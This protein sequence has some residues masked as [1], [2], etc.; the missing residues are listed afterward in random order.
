MSTGDVSARVKSNTIHDI[1][2]MHFGFE[3]ETLRVHQQMTFAPCDF[4]ACVIATRATQTDGF[5]TLAV[6][7][8]C[9][10]LSF[11]SHLFTHLHAQCCMK[12]FPEAI[13]IPQ[14]KVVIHGFLRRQI[15]G[16]QTPSASASQQIE[17]GIDDL[18]VAME[19]R[20]SV[21]R[22]SREKRSNAVPFRIAQID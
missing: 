17:N 16:K 20:P 10:G 9:T 3:D 21:K 14:T 22:G 6:N 11:T 12:S 13:F 18:T 7:D 2:C 15:V 8:A 19:A 5:D 1:G 4:L